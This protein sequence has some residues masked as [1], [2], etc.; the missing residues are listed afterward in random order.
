MFSSTKNFKS[1]GKYFNCF[2]MLLQ[3]L[4]GKKK[5]IK[6]KLVALGLAQSPDFTDF[7]ES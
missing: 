6:K 3:Y 5:K 4:K 2:L 1:A 7:D